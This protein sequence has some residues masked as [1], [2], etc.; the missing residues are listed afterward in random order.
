MGLTEVPDSMKHVPGAEDAYEQ[1]YPKYI[2]NRMLCCNIPDGGYYATS[3]TINLAGSGC[4]NYN[5]IKDRGSS[6]WAP[7]HEYG[8]QNQGA[9]HMA[10]TTEISNNFFSN[11]S[12]YKGGAATSRGWPLMSMQDILVM[13]DFSWPKVT[14]TPEKD[15]IGVYLYFKLYLYYHAMGHNPLFYQKLFKLLRARP[16]QKAAGSITGGKDYLHF[17]KMACDAAG[18]DL[19]EF[20]E[21]HGFFKPV[22]NMQMS[23]YNT[24]YMTTT[25]TQINAA[26]RYVA[27]KNYPKANL[28]MVFIED[29]AVASYQADGVTPRYPYDGGYWI[30][31]V[32]NCPTDF[33]GAQYSA[34]EGD[35]PSRP[36][37][38]SY[39]LTGKRWRLNVDASDVT[40]AAGVIFYDSNGE[41]AYVAATSSVT[42]PDAV[43]S[44]I[45]HSK[46]IIVLT[47]GTKL[48]LYKKDEAGV[49]ALQI[50]HGDGTTT[51]RYTKGGDN[52]M[53]SAARD[54]Q[55]AVALVEGDNV[56]DTI[57]SAQNVGV[58]GVAQHLVL[59]DSAD[60][61]LPAN[62][63]AQHITYHRRKLQAGWNT[64]CLPFAIAQS[65]L[66]EGAKIEVLDLTKTTSEVLYFKGVES[67]EAGQPCLIYM[68]EGNE[69]WLCEKEN[70]DGIPFVGSVQPTE[71]SFYM[72]GSFRK[73]IIGAGHYQM[74][75]DGTA[76]DATTEG[77]ENYPFRAYVSTTE[78]DTNASINATHGS[79][80]TT[81]IESLDDMS[82]QE[83][84]TCYDLQGRKVTQPQRGVLYILNG[85]KVVFN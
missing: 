74:N 65:D 34:F 33:P 4:F 3:Y 61:Y 30:F 7:A 16:M 58:N 37:N 44:K 24:W 35:A 53:L 76:F 32:E 85:Q 27:N 64:L 70:A 40:S 63:T 55:N 79:L 83:G 2:N 19:T 18:E 22:D 72:N 43:A 41:I 75:A 77:A 68:P 67:V 21:Y 36:H 14:F 29:R 42:L 1:L 20:F 6:V 12:I 69:N 8:H 47:D 81:G 5:S 52:A 15:M 71:A 60:F 31:S 56:P 45:D 66:G 84:N 51:T 28:A 10:A 50:H 25:L 46:T 73:E 9:I 26:K 62:Y 82:T 13:G 11:L 48:P 23:S 80:D 78:T 57:A 54:G 17:Y 49:Y 38:L 39:S 59:T